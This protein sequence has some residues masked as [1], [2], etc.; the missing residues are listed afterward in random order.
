MR[1]ALF[2]NLPS[3]GAKRH[4]FEQI[5]ELA[6][7]GHEIVEFAPTTA[8]FAFCSLT[9]FVKEQRA[10][11]AHKLEL[12]Q[13]RIRF[14]TPYV[15]AC[16]LV[17][18]LRRTQ[19]INRIIAS[20][21]D[22]GNYDLVL[23]KDCHIIFNPYVLRFLS[24]PSIFQCHHGGRPTIDRTGQENPA[25]ASTA[26]RLK[27]AYYYSAH[28][29]V[30]HYMHRD[31]MRNIRSATRVLTNSG[32]SERILFDLFGV[33]AHAIY[34]GIDTQV[35]RPQN[36]P[37]ADYVLSVGALI[38]RKG[39]RFLISALAQLDPTLRPPLFIAANAIDADEE[40]TLRA[41]AVESGVDLRI[42]TITE[43]SRLVSVYSQAKALVYAPLQEALGLAPLEAMACGTPVVA[44]G[45]GGV[46]ETVVDGV[47]GL[48]VK[49]DPSQFAERLGHLLSDS[50]LKQQMSDAAIE[51][52][53][54]NWTWQQAVDN[55]ENEFRLLVRESKDESGSKNLIKQ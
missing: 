53:R 25:Q 42:E 51:C 48:L 5:R 41:M 38:Y 11:Q 26:W 3:G 29:F 37:E 47:T 22:D 2:H 40:R 17:A 23:A 1:V 10:Y 45:E 4:T 7:R 18:H 21:I 32:Y 49:R 27:Q 54:R 31:A 34:P 52:V 55:L 30:A 14:A 24:T 20:D 8:D 15:H 43:S 35:F 46:R 12:L 6:K 19:H 28:T 50:S 44:V 36:L 33:D 39:H 13:R 9:P 16:Q